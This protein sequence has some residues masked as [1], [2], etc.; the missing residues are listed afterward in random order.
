MLREFLGES[1]DYFVD[2]GEGS[3]LAL[4]AYEDK[5]NA[6]I[7]WNGFIL[8][9]N[10]W[11]RSPLLQ[12]ATALPLVELEGWED[13]P[14]NEVAGVHLGDNHLSVGMLGPQECPGDIFPASFP[15]YGLDVIKALQDMGILLGNDYVSLLAR[16]KKL[17]MEARENSDKIPRLT[18]N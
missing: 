12:P 5:W 4:V 8:R 2:F 3:G 17:S 13:S 1:V 11:Q 9:I 10:Q 16:L 7:F 14:W 6:L 15:D 18:E